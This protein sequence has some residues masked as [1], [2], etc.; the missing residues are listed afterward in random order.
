MCELCGRGGVRARPKPASLPLSRL[1][2]KLFFPIS[3][4]PCSIFLSFYL[5]LV[6]FFLPAVKFCTC[7]REAAPNCASEPLSEPSKNTQT[8]HHPRRGFLRRGEP[9]N[10][11]KCSPGGSDTQLGLQ[12]AS[13]TTHLFFP[14]VYCALHPTPEETHT[15]TFL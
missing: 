10:F 13:L 2:L 9:G 14:P 12:S 1:S 3:C 8:G 15:T 4:F 5:H 6:Y 11:L 7:L